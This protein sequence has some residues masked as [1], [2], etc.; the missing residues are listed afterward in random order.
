MAVMG[1]QLDLYLQEGCPPKKG[2]IF[3]DPKTGL[4]FREDLL[5]NNEYTERL[6]VTQ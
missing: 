4:A 3:L 5:F 6:H 2:D 1:R